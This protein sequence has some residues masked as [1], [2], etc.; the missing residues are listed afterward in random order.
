MKLVI[1]SAFIILSK[2]VVLVLE[3]LFLIQPLRSL[4]P[5]DAQ[6]DAILVPEQV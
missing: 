3:T 1:G 2:G 5:L 6:L 4:Q